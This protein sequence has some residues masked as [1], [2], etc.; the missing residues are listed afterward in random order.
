MQVRYCYNL[1]ACKPSLTAPPAP[2]TPIASSKRLKLSAKKDGVKSPSPAAAKGLAL[3]PQQ[4][5]EAELIHKGT[6]GVVP[7]ASKSLFSPLLVRVDGDGG[8][9]SGPS[10]S[11]R[12]GSAE[13]KHRAVVDAA[14]APQSVPP[15]EVEEEEEEVFNPYYFISSLPPHS[16]IVPDMSKICLPPPAECRQSQQKPTLVLD[17]DETLV[18]CTV[19][20]IEKP[21]L[22][23]PVTFNGTL[24][25]VYVRKR[26]YLDYFLESVSRSYEVVVFTASQK[27]YADVLLDLLDPEH[28]YI[29]YRLFR[30]S[31]LLVQGNYL[32]DLSVLGRDL[33]RTVLVDNSPHAYGFQIDNGIPIESWFEDDT[34]TEL[35]KL[36]GFLRQLF[37]SDISQDVRP[38][39]R[40]HFGTHQLVSDASRGLPVRLSAPPF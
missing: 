6:S 37:S 20:P 21:D 5:D 15:Q 10:A 28:K 1:N 11:S 4:Q 12:P 19:E 38:L 13:E 34:D 18:H 26:P 8:G 36:L 24:Y 7:G 40:Q 32:K 9:D 29:K 23:F 22:V 3:P 35:L 30:E 14:A 2:N 33:T 39:V 17:L 27:V 31:C 16:S 25:D